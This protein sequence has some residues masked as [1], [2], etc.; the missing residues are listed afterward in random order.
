MIQIGV[1]VNRINNKGHCIIKKVSSAP[2]THSLTL[3]R[4]T[5]LDVVMGPSVSS[6]KLTITPSTGVAEDDLELF[7]CSIH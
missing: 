2:A 3:R 4:S 5:V 6:A 1:G 7:F